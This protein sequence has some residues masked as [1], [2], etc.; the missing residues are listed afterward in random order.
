MLLQFLFILLIRESDGGFL[1]NTFRSCQPPVYHLQ[2]KEPCNVP[3]STAQQVSLPAYS[4]DCLFNAERQGSS[5]KQFLV[6]LA[7]LQKIDCNRYSIVIFFT[8]C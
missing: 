7:G 4:P 2:I 6:L 1:T 8:F 5:E 3:F